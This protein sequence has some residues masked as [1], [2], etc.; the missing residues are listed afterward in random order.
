MRK[1]I[2]FLA[3][4][5]LLTVAQSA[6]AQYR[7]E[8]GF[9]KYLTVT[10]AV[11]KPDSTLITNATTR[12]QILNLVSYAENVRVTMLSLKAT[13]TKAGKITLEQSEDG[14]NYIRL[15]SLPASPITKDSTVFTNTAGYQYDYIDTGIWKSRYLRAC[16]V[17]TGTQTTYVKILATVKTR[18]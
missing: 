12:C 1:T 6:Q 2:L 7:G 11:D 17:P 16:T 5:F 9:Q 3:V 15:K 8:G 10:Q 13:G 4:A 14:V 18:P